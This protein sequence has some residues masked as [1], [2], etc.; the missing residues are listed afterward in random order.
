MGRIR[1]ALILYAVYGMLH[2]IYFIEFGIMDIIMKSHHHDHMKRHGSGHMDRLPPAL[3]TL[4]IMI[5]FMY[6]NKI[7][8]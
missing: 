8:L 1:Y 7:M 4:V 3:L 2:T 5:K 6:M